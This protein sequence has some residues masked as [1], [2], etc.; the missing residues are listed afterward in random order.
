MYPQDV[1]LFSGTIEENIAFGKN[2]V[3]LEDII[4]AA[5]RANA[6]EFI[7]EMPLRYNTMVGER[8]ATLSG[9][10]K[11]RLALA[12][13]LLGNP[14]ILI[15]DEAT[16]NLDSISERAIHETIESISDEKTTIIIAHRLSTIMRC[17]KIIC[18]DKGAIT[19]TGTHST[20]L[21]NKST[22]Y[23]LWKGQLAIDYDMDDK[24]IVQEI[25]L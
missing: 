20:L 22:Y 13:A 8:G 19:E 3:P 16:S 7:N 18:M 5:K 17:D 23:N 14:Y 10:Q 15:L 4:E 25:V 1:V 2:N 24:K 6:H 21:K 9:G 12:R 11:Q